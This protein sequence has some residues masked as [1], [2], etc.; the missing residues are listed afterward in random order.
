[1]RSGY[2]IVFEG[3][4]GAGKTTQ[5]RL[6]RHFLEAKKV[7]TVVTREPGGSTLGRRVRSILLAKRRRDL[8]P[9]AEVLLYE[10]DR[11]Q[12]VEEVVRPALKAG[13]VVLSDRFED[14][15]TVYQG[16]CRGLGV[17][18]VQ[19]L[20][21]IATGGLRPDLVVVLD[22][23][24]ELRHK[25]LVTRPVLDRMES[26]GDP[27]HARVQAGFLRLAK[28]EKRRFVVIDA[29]RS[30][31]KVAREVRTVVSKRLGL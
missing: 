12:H 5:I 20:N 16:H 28:A 15:S 27:F 17:G 30:V 14:S 29:T 9:R 13:A 31:S 24:S 22:I 19:K 4:E 1:M 3:G 7:K 6:L 2:F 18:W 26:A 10:A 8:C 23:P 21:K 25:R 11:A